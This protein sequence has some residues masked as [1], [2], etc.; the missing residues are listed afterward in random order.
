MS[1]IG[2]SLS[3]NYTKRSFNADYVDYFTGTSGEYLEKRLGGEYKIPDTNPNTIVKNTINRVSSL[4]KPEHHDVDLE[5]ISEAIR[6]MDSS[7]F[8][9]VAA[10]EFEIGSKEDSFYTTKLLYC[11]TL[12]FLGEKQNAILHLSDRNDKLTSQL[13][14]DINPKEI[15]ILKSYV[16]DM[17][18]YYARSK[19]NSIEKG[20]K[21][22]EKY[23][24]D[25]SGQC[26]FSYLKYQNNPC[27]KY[28]NIFFFQGG[29]DGKENKILILDQD[30][31]KALEKIKKG[32]KETYS[33]PSIS[34]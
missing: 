29:G 3:V 20:N 19:S 6:I 7:I 15:I 1:R 18:D 5:K 13:F 8:E 26:K 27:S 28:F 4:T 24:N 22:L 33:Q 17:Y 2:R 9:P 23:A 31:F 10:E 14:D 12:L 34:R 16:M 25:H 30:E 11:H 32:E 21:F